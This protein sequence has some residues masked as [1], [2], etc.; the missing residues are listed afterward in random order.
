MKVILKSD[1]EKLGRAG[2]VKDV[3][4]GFARNF[5][6][7]RGMAEAATPSAIRWF[8]KGKEKRESAREKTLSDAKSVAKKLSSVKLSFSRSVSEGGTLFGS[9]GKSDIV[10]S[11]KTSG[12]NVG[13]N[14]IVLEAAF[15]EIGEFD[16][17][18]RLAP[19][20]VTKIKVAIAPRV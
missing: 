19:D 15:K 12:F 17:E 10:K 1:I 5:L 18:V 3:R 6:F 7:P 8:E 4:R 9:V 16:V 2:D 20:A 13:K 11:L 14:S